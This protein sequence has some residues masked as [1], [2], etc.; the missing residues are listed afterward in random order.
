MVRLVSAQR[1]L[2]GGALRW[3]EV[4]PGLWSTRPGIIIILVA[5]LLGLG[6]LWPVIVGAVASLVIFGMLRPVVDGIVLRA[7]HVEDA[8][9]LFGCDGLNGMVCWNWL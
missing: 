6:I 7:G 2:V 5:S 1:E 9:G 3:A 4:V 8:G